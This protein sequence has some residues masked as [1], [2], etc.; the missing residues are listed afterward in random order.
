MDKTIEDLKDLFSSIICL[1]VE[2]I[3]F[4]PA[5]EILDSITRTAKKGYE[6]CQHALQSVS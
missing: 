5:T 2:G 1:R 3:E 4:Y 6:L